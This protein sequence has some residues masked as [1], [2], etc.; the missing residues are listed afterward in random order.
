MPFRS[1]SVR[2]ARSWPRVYGPDQGLSRSRSGFTS[3]PRPSTDG[4]CRPPSFL[5]TGG[6]RTD[7]TQG[8]AAL[9]KIRVPPSCFPWS[10]NGAAGLRARHALACCSPCSATAP[11][12]NPASL[13][14]RLHE[15]AHGQVGSGQHLLSSVHAEIS[16][17][18]RRTASS[19]S[20]ASFAQAA[21][22][23]GTSSGPSSA[24]CT[25]VC[26]QSAW[27][28]SAST[29]ARAMSLTAAAVPI[30]ARACAVCRVTAVSSTSSS[31]PTST[32]AASGTSAKEARSRPARARCVHEGDDAS[33]KAASNPPII[34]GTTRPSH[35]PRRRSN[36]GPNLTTRLTKND[37]GTP[38]RQPSP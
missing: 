29:T 2:S 19:W 21:A 34:S 7:Y 6:Q 13:K 38:P 1:L 30:R 36:L 15:P 25:P 9:E 28:P 27:L 37:R 11:F 10:C 18:P 14:R 16:A 8:G 35:A 33:A 31:S 4:R 22:T 5:A 24:S 20:P 12:T 3:K 23:S 26:S 17:A 32:S